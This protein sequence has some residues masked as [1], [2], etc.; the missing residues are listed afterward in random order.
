MAPWKAPGKPGRFQVVINGQTHPEEFG[1]E[2][3]DWHWQAGGSVSLKAG[4]N[5]VALRDLTGFD[6]RCDA[7]L[8]SNVPGYTP[9]EGKTLAEAR[10]N[11][12]N[13]GGKPE[14]AGEF[15]LV[16]VGGG[17][18][19]LGAAI[20]AARQ[21][22]KV[23]LIQDRFVLGGNGSSEIGVWAMGGTMRG[24]YPRLGEIVE[25]FADRAPDSPGLPEDFKD[26][27]KETV[28]R[29]EKT[30]SLFLGHFAHGVVQDAPGAAIQA[31][32]ALDVRSGR[33]RV[34]RGK[35]FVDCT[36]HGTVGALAGAKHSMLEK[37]HMGMALT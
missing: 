20:S 32:A 6:G 18:A 34:F 8:L 14:D 15:D 11:W 1:A 31:V 24:K 36:G 28:C 30:L 5:T 33:E 19:G 3:A 29:N 9:P 23:A 10:K 21:S 17:Y 26:A 4:K 2:G 7:L 13:P 37:G 16:V 35:L 25:E 27:L 22:L 12:L